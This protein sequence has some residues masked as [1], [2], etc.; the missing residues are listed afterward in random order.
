[1]AFQITEP[2]TTRGVNKVSGQGIKSK[3]NEVLTS[4]LKQFTTQW[5]PDC[6]LHAVVL[7]AQNYSNVREL[8]L[9]MGGGVVQMEGGINFS[10]IK[11][12]RGCKIS[13]SFHAEK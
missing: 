10:A 2:I 5:H 1:M 9:F 3:C 12:R 6:P 11:L 13:V 8:S 7:L 4:H